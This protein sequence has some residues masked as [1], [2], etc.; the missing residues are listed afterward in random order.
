MSSVAFYGVLSSLFVLEYFEKQENW[1]EHYS[2]QLCLERCR[3][4]KEDLH[5]ASMRHPMAT[6]AVSTMNTVIT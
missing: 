3:R 2:D 6:M 5:F 1:E 4:T